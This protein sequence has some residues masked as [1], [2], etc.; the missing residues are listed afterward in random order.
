MLINVISIAILVYLNYLEEDV[1]WIKTESELLDALSRDVDKFTKSCDEILFKCC[2]WDLKIN[3]SEIKLQPNGVEKDWLS[4]TKNLVAEAKSCTATFYT[5]QRKRFYFVLAILEPINI[6]VHEIKRIKMAISDHLQKKKLYSFDIYG[7]MEVSRSKIRSLKIVGYKPPDHDPI[8]KRKPALTESF[9]ETACNLIKSR[10][11]ASICGMAEEIQ[12]I[13]SLLFLYAFLKD[14]HGLELESEIEKAWWRQAK[15]IINVTELAITI[16]CRPAQLWWIP[17]FDKWKAMSKLKKKMKHIHTTFVDLLDK[18]DKYGFKF[19]R[20]LELSGTLCRPLQPQ[21]LQQEHQEVPLQEIQQEELGEQ[22]QQRQEQEQHQLREQQEQQQQQQDQPQEQQEEPEHPQEQPQEELEEQQEQQQEQEQQEQQQDEPQEQQEDPEHQQE[23][24]EEQQQQQQQEDWPQEQPLEELEEQQQQDQDDRNISSAIKEI[25]L[26]LDDVPR[27]WWQIKNIAKI[28]ESSIR[29]R[30]KKP[31]EQRDIDEDIEQHPIL[32]DIDQ[33]QNA[34][35]LLQRSIGVF[36]VENQKETVE[37][38]SIVGFEEDIPELLTTIFNNYDNSRKNSPVIIPIVGMNGIGKTTLVKEIYY[39]SSIA[40]HFPIRA[41]VRVQKKENILLATRNMNE[42]I[43]SIKVVRHKLEE[44]PCFLVLDGISSNEEFDTLEKDLFPTTT[45]GSIILLTTCCKTVA[46]HVNPR[47][48]VHL[49]LRTKG[50]SWLLFEQTTCRIDAN[51]KKYAQTLGR[52]GG[53]PV[54]IFSLGSSITG[55]EDDVKELPSLEQINHGQNQKP[56]LY[57]M[58]NNLEYLANQTVR[59]CLSYFILFPKDYEIPARRLITLWVA[60]GLVSDGADNSVEHVAKNILLELINRNIIQ[61]VEIKPN[62]DVKTCR[63]PCTLREHIFRDNRRTAR[64]WSTNPSLGHRFGYRFDGDDP[65]LT[66]N[67]E[68]DNNALQP[69]KYPLSILFF[70]TREGNRPGEDIE[71]FL[72][73]KIA[74]ERFIKLKVLDLERVFRPQLPNSIGNL[75]ELRYLGLRWT[76]LQ[77]IPSTIGNL[78]KLQTLDL[79]RTNLLTLP[80]TIWKLQKL[81]HLYLDKNHPKEFMHKAKPSSLLN[82]QTLKGVYLDEKSPLLDGLP[83][84]TN[85]HNLKLKFQLNETQQNTGWQEKIQSLEHLQ[86]LKLRSIASSNKPLNLNLG[87]LTMLQKLS[88]VRLFGKLDNLPVF[89][90]SLSDLTLSASGLESDP[91]PD[92]EKLP[93]LKALCMYADSFIGKKMVCS[94]GGFPKLLVLK[95]WKLMALDEWKIEKKAM[96]NLRELDIRQ[97]KRLE[98]TL[99]LDHLN[100]QKRYSED[101]SKKFRF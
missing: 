36:Y 22:Q 75:I 58:K 94:A 66:Q 57:T 33:I 83:K 46:S 35:I 20:E 100:L 26:K 14:S 29:F 80:K 78:R 55:K 16:E 39:H 23:E 27:T 43:L 97:C 11:E 42:K 30:M 63:M 95:I 98:V 47:G 4:A 7:L 13:I 85:L 74:G 51:R 28:A 53:L 18:K 71:Y 60:E 59:D 73:R 87:D 84:L 5:L 54:A 21:E 9:N 34:I 31:A 50:E 44:S 10:I 15:E 49:R 70:D 61:V 19:M 45:E 65:N 90:D 2:L 86:S 12:L 3:Q 99:G 25:Q 77:D 67:H 68:F 8:Q 17:G 48:T 56:W 72:R 93:Q 82:L 96:Q 76:Y 91:M 1:R 79:K 32:K 69:K 38:T 89:P 81:R 37:A 62:G 88:T 101:M 92:L 41:W 40:E 6:N 64:S 24:L 52:F